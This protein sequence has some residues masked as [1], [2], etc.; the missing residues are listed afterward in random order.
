MPRK[1]GRA[2]IKW[3]A[4]KQCLPTA[5]TV[6]AVWYA[7]AA[8]YLI[9]TGREVT[10]GAVARAADLLDIVPEVE[11]GA[12]VLRRL[13][14][15]H[16]MEKAHGILSNRAHVRRPDLYT[17]KRKP[18]QRT[19]PRPEPAFCERA[20]IK[21]QSDRLCCDASLIDSA[22]NNLGWTHEEIERLEPGVVDLMFYQPPRP[23]P[24]FEPLY[25]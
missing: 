15:A 3:L 17:V 18:P 9:E 1:N 21:E 24:S 7:L 19:P 5:P 22:L 10:P 13:R 11:N 16:L 4:S 8:D 20:L 12:C 6:G 25:G 23:V 2:L 14:P